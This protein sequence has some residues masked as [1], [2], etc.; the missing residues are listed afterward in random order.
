VPVIS[1][2]RLMSFITSGIYDL[3][4]H[5]T[6]TRQ[7][8]QEYFNWHYILRPRSIFVDER[9]NAITT[10]VETYIRLIRCS[11]F[12]EDRIGET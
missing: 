9:I 8:K 3:Q 7:R 6:S 11:H 10:G 2:T 5:N 4:T 1:V 12:T